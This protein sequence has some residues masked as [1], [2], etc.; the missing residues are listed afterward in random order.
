M[1][2]AALVAQSAIRTNSRPRS[3][4]G[5]VT[6]GSY[7]CGSGDGTPTSDTRCPLSHSLQPITGEWY[8]HL[9]KGQRFRV[10]SA[11][12]DEDLIEIQNFDGDLEELEFAEW[13]AM[14]L[15]HAAAPEDWT[16]PMDDVEKDEIDDS[17]TASET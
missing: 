6:S 10:V 2:G 11:E 13:F 7:T 3:R 14:D 9:D 8:R 5:P 4:R 17:E 16:G 1:R 15:E 12:K